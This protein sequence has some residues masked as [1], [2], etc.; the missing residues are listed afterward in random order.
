MD[1]IIFVHIDVAGE[2]HFVGRLWIKERRGVESSTFEYSPEWRSSNISFPLEPALLLG[3]GSYHTGKT[4]F[5]SIGDSAPDRWGCTLMNRLEARRAKKEN[6]KARR[7]KSSDYLL[8]V[9]DRTRQGALRFSTDKTGPF[10]ASYFN[11][12]IPPLVKLESLLNASQNIVMRE[13]TDQNIKDLV[14]PGSSLGG[15]RPKAVVL[16][17]NSR[18]LIAKFPS[19]NDEWDVPLW[20]FISLNIAKKAGINVP[21][22]FLEKVLGKNVLLLDRFDRDVNRYRI[23]FLSA[24]S[25]L[26]AQ[27]HETKSYLEIKDA[28]IEYGAKTTKDIKELWKRIVLNI[29]ISNT[30]D[31]LR[32]HGF[33]YDGKIGWVLSPIY[34][35][36][37]TP[38]HIKARFLKTNINENNNTAS[39]ALAF[40]VAED[41]RLN[42]SE[43]RKI[44]K[45]V[46]ESVKHWKKEALQL[47]ANKQE[48]DFMY[49][50]F[51]HDDLNQALK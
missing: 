28:L 45:L 49:S 34:D 19:P 23:P 17:R 36:E 3:E 40:E 31:H 48:I 22:F 10:L 38:E 37:P 44:A 27:D 25:M 21:G 18:L 2:T 43:A 39:L 35:L 5:G 8:M 7:L 11:S 20:E 41:F 29:L 42:I 50:A 32:N 12:S 46:G 24:M 13:E 47:G 14:E 33:L 6:R 1:K 51:E 26:N 15:A 4:L 30:D 9:D 16:N